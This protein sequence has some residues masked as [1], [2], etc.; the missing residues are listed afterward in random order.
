MFSGRGNRSVGIGCRGPNCRQYCVRLTIIRY[1][2]VHPSEI[3]QNIQTLYDRITFL[4]GNFDAIS[5]DFADIRN[6]S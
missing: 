2:G 3:S 6:K 5:I 4:S 1:S